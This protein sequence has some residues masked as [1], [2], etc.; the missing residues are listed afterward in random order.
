MKL[1]DKIGI[2]LYTVRE[3]FKTPEEAA[4]TFRRLRAL[5]YE[6]AQTAGCY[7]MEY[8]LFYRLAHDAGIEIVGTH[9]DFDLMVNDIDAAIARHKALHTTNMGIGGFGAANVEEAQ[10]FIETANRIGARAAQEGMKFTYHNHSNEF[11]RLENGRTLMDMLVEGLDPETTSF[12][13]DTHWVQNAG[14]DV[15]AWI[16]KLSGRID[17]LHLKDMSVVRD[18][19]GRVHNQ[20]A[21]IG[22]GNMDFDRII[23]AARAAG[24]RYYC[25][26]QDNC[27][28]EN[29]EDDAGFSARY[30]REHFM[31]D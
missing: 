24:V 21:A 31:Q 25:V 5:G 8:D 16:E 27:P 23:R 10:R 19:D 17:I 1:I 12:V 11:I 28:Q 26:E 2:Q 4:E 14:G 6:E 13:L 22:R 7:G 3:N 20:I 9:D 29:F 18:A 30:L 15:C